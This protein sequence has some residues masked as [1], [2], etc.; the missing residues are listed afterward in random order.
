LSSRPDEEHH[1]LLISERPEAKK[2]ISQISFR[3]ESLNELKDF[4]RHLQEK[5]VPIDRIRTHGH[6]ISIYC[7][8]PEKNM[9][10]IYWPTGLDV[11]GPI[12]KPVELERP[13]EE[14]LKSHLA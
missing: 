6:S 8:D 11:V 2:N 7:Y 3:V 12:A 1:E 10:E 13:E 4:Y 14:I 5:A 9:I